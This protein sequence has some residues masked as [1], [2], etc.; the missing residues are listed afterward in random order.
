MSQAKDN[1]ARNN[2]PDQYA[3][4]DPLLAKGKDGK[5]SKLQAQMKKRNREWGKG[6]GP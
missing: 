2:D 5:L 1:M 3:V 4:V 6:S